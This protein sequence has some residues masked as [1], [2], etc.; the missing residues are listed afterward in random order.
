MAI[1]KTATMASILIS[2][3]SI[4]I[5]LLQKTATRTQ[6]VIDGLTITM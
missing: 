2:V 5:S 4:L 6:L 3:V 1:E